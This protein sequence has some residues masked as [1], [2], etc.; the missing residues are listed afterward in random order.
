MRPGPR[1]AIPLPPPLRGTPPSL[2]LPGG[3]GRSVSGVDSL[4]G[5]RAEAVTAERH[6][7]SR[8]QGVAF[9]CA[10]FSYLLRFPGSE[11]PAIDTVWNGGDWRELVAEDADAHLDLTDRLTGE[12]G[13]LPARGSSV[14]GRPTVPGPVA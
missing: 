10:V 8:W 11:R 2:V 6:G 1:R 12:G 14:G 3:R 9:R 4:D 13:A 7:A 5:D